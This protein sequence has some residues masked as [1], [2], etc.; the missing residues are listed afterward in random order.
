[1]LTDRDVEEI[2]RGVFL[3]YSPQPTSYTGVVAMVA[4]KAEGVI[5]IDTGVADYMPIA[6]LP[7]LTALGVG[8][9]DIT[10][11]CST[12]GHFDHSGGSAAL[13][14]ISGAPVY[15]SAGDV[16]LAG[17][18]P[19]V[20]IREGDKLDLGELVFTVLDTPGHTLGS[21]CFYDHAHRF[22]VVGDAVQGSG[23]ASNGL[24]PVY[25]HSGRDYRAS[26]RRLLD[27]PVDVLVMGHPLEWSGTAS[28]VHRGE[29][30]RALL[31]ESLDASTII[32]SAVADSQREAACQDLLT[33]RRAILTRLTQHPLFAH[34][35]PDGAIGEST[36]ATLR[37]EFR[38]LG[39]DVN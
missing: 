18:S 9:A 33:L 1:V 26:L 38:D 36:N 35:N 12:H 15:L 10:A 20:T 16:E 7:A 34:I 27:L 37:S 17:F 14:D 2:T 23:S 11:I 32:A 29:E 28:C 6:L 30:S 8:P 3:A 39:V 25:F 24:L 31:A 22:L 19:D 5:V 13:H 4:A 21:V